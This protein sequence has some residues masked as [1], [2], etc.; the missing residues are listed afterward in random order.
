[1]LK[2]W[3]R[4]WRTIV[5]ADWYRSVMYNSYK[6][7]LHVESI[8]DFW[9]LTNEIVWKCFRSFVWFYRQKLQLIHCPSFVLSWCICSHSSDYCWLAPLIVIDCFEQ[10]V[11]KIHEW[12]AVAI[13]DICNWIL[14][15]QNSDYLLCQFIFNLLSGMFNVGM[16]KMLYI[17]NRAVYFQRLP[18]C[19]HK[20]CSF[21]C[22]H[23]LDLQWQYL[24][25]EIIIG[26]ALV[27]CGA[28]SM[29]WSGISI[30]PHVPAFDH[31]TPLQ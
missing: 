23:F 10:W 21:L 24:L 29:Q 3:R 14:S 8:D 20:L 30:C 31:C 19:S 9:L 1:M 12:F 6:L 17:T 18:F 27:I 4:P 11:S 22:L 2:D 26:T 5:G 16:L 13:A 7:M 28:G 15:T 25:P